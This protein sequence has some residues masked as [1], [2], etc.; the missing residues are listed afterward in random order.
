M[1][2]CSDEL[3]KFY[4]GTFTSA[5]RVLYDI[6][7]SLSDRS[8]VVSEEID[9]ELMRSSLD[10]NKKFYNSLDRAPNRY[11]SSI[12]KTREVVIVHSRNMLGRLD[13]GLTE[14]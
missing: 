14:F 8:A 1:L 10:F 12:G 7:S 4:D 6:A 3:Y 2:M 11:S 9:E 13:Y 5:R